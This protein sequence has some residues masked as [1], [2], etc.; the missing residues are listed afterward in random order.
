ML[1]Y[2][3]DNAVRESVS[4]LV[5]PIKFYLDEATVES[6]HFRYMADK[7]VWAL[8]ESNDADDEQS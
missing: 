5:E 3:L 7:F 8:S 4:N 2:W 6:D 1:T